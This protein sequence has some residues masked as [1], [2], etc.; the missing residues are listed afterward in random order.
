MYFHIITQNLSIEMPFLKY[1]DIEFNH[2]I[3]ILNKDI[4]DSN[5]MK[6]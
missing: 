6:I 5:N 1:N 2:P 4:L 3:S